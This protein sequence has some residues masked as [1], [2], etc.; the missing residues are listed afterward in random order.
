MPLKILDHDSHNTELWREGVTTKMRIS[1]LTGAHQ[2]C[3][4]DQWCEEGLGAPM[5]L[6]AVEEVLEVME[7][8]AEVSVGSETGILTKNQSVIIPAGTRHGFINAG[9]GLLHVR[10][11]LAACIF[12]A[13]Y[14]ASNE[15]SRRWVP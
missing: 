1:A 3:I 15:N 7:G 2:L 8:R 14:D 6:H 11:T 4:F 9:T 10:A 13:S 5:H 12:E